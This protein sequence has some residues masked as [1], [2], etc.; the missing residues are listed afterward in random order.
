[1][2][3]ATNA[4]WKRTVMKNSEREQV[5]HFL[6]KTCNLGVFLQSCTTTAKKCTKKCAARARLLFLLIIDLS[7][8]LRRSRCLSITRFYILFERIIN[9]IESFAF[10][11]GWLNTLWPHTHDSQ[12]EQLLLQWQTLLIDTWYRYGD[13]D[14]SVIRQPFSRQI[15]HGCLITCPFPALHM[16]A[17]YRRHLHDMDMI[18]PFS[19]TFTPP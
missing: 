3:A 8:F 9:I 13:S 11:P 19:I 14:S 6:D 7:L 10:S 12:Y 4:R 5:R 2:L 1:M 17:L 16:V 15:R 18:L